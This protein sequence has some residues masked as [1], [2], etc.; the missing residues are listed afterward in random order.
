MNYRWELAQTLLTGPVSRVAQVHKHALG[1]LSQ[2][3]LL[4][5]IDL[6]LE[7]YREGTP[8]AALRVGFLPV[9]GGTRARSIPNFLDHPDRSAPRWCVAGA[10]VRDTR[11]LLSR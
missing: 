9:V 2:E 1:A 8:F 4:R 5:L 3:D 10:D 11:E 6:N 7:I